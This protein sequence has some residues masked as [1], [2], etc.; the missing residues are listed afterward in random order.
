[1]DKAND[2]GVGIIN[3]EHFKRKVL[4]FESK[5]E[6]P[7]TPLHLGL[8]MYTLSIIIGACKI[9]DI[10]KK[11]TFYGAEYDWRAV[12]VAYV[13]MYNAIRRVSDI[14]YM[15]VNKQVFA[16]DA[17]AIG[18]DP[19]DSMRKLHAM[20]GM[21]GEHGGE[22]AEALL[23]ALQP[24]G[25]LDMV[26]VLEEL[27]DGH[28]YEAVL[29]DTTG[30]KFVD[31][32]NIVDRKLQK[33]YGTA[34]TDKGALQR[35]KQAERV[36]MEQQMSTMRDDD[37][38]MVAQGMAIMDGAFDRPEP[39]LPVE[40]RTLKADLFDVSLVKVGGE[41]I[42]NVSSDNTGTPDSDGGSTD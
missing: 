36:V 11:A 39:G 9:I 18:N 14:L 28:W 20:L 34:Y 2:D 24:L 42:G 1:M 3:F 29:L 37:S 30:H 6:A 38:P 16:V 26:N 23:A 15:P 21:I 41:P 40:F 8:L 7:R 27:G 12:E 4:A 32:L 13:G 5:P 31:S 33:R 25:T 22:F 17:P 19:M 35:D 10:I